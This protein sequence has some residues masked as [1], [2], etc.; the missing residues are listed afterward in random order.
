V[1]APFAAGPAAARYRRIFRA[2]GTRYAAWQGRAAARHGLEWSDPWSDRRLAE[3]VLAVP[4]HVVN[5]LAEPKR[6]ARRALASL[7]APGGPDRTRKIIPEQLFD[8]G[9]RDRGIAVV[10]RLFTDS[11]SERRGY[12]DAAAFLSAYDRFVRREPVESD[13]WWPIAL[14]GWLRVHWE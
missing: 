13:P 9:F 12:V 7:G 11:R 10:R 8:R 14:E 6:L 4:Q 3:Y 2:G 1:P 5:R